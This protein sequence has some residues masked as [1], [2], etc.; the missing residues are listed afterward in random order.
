MTRVLALAMG[1]KS[2]EEWCLPCRLEGLTRC[3]GLLGETSTADDERLV[4]SR[5]R[6]EVLQQT[7]QPR[8]HPH[9]TSGQSRP[10]VLESRTNFDVSQGHDGHISVTFITC[11]V[12]VAV[13]MIHGPCIHPSSIVCAV[14]AETVR[15]LTDLASCGANISGSF[16][17]HSCRRHVRPTN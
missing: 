17:R 14:R 1:S 13:P 7:Q 9:G 12:P 8:L 16:P 6:R 11:T 2:C 4:G 5:R 10:A 3:D 15:A